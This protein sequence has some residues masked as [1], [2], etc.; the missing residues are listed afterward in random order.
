MI[1]RLDVF[2]CCY[3][4]NTILCLSYIAFGME[5]KWEIWFILFPPSLFP[6]VFNLPAT[7]NALSLSVVFVW[8]DFI[9]KSSCFSHLFRLLVLFLSSI[10][11]LRE[12]LNVMSRLFSRG[13]CAVSGW[14]LSM[15]VRG[16]S[17][18]MLGQFSSSSQSQSA[19]VSVCSLDLCAILLRELSVF[20]QLGV[21]STVQSHTVVVCV[22]VCFVCRCVPL[23]W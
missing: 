19:T 4:S 13:Q 9:G 17:L 15:W 6:S 14:C 8:S 7:G 18:L 1:Q 12:E 2:F 22:C 16:I 3:R 23:F 10:L 21:K 5:P 20:V 11:S